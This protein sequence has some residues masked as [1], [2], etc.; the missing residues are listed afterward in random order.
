MRGVKLDDDTYAMAQAVAEHDDK[1]FS[2]WV[3][4]LIKKE[5][6]RVNRKQEGLLS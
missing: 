6:R 3:R 4:G 5:I 2:E 1:F